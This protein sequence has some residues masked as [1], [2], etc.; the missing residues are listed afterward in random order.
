MG[1]RLESLRKAKKAKRNKGE[2]MKPKGRES[3]ALTMAKREGMS[4]IPFTR[5]TWGMFSAKLLSIRETE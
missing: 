5:L 3:Q 2:Y 1:T 4:K